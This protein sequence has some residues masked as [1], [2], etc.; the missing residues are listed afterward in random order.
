VDQD[1]DYRCDFYPDCVEGV[2]H[3]CVDANKDG[4][5]DLCYF[6]MIHDCYDRNGDRYCD[7]CTCEISSRVKLFVISYLDN[8][9]PITMD[10]YDEKG[11]TVQTQQVYGN[12]AEEH[13]R[14]YPDSY[15]FT[16]SKYGHTSLNGSFTMEG[17]LTQLRLKLCPI[18]DVSGDGKLNMG[19]TARIYSHIRGSSLQTD[20]YA[21]ACADASGD[22]KLNMGDISRVYSHIRGTKPL[23]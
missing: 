13:F 11:L 2:G 17:E 7:Y 14:I 8:D 6:G 15:T 5:C 9:S 12:S 3:D 23:F 20:D 16:L 1:G 22:G 19:D 21:L 4:F 10:I 18:G